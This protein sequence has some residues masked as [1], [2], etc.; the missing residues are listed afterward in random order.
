M[1]TPKRMYGCC[2][3]GSHFKITDLRKLDLNRMD[4]KLVQ[5][6]SPALC[7]YH[8]CRDCKRTC[9][10]CH[11]WVPQLQLRVH[12]LCA[13]CAVVKPPPKKRVRAC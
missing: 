6:L 2:V 11:A 12:G 7:E 13:T 5:R 9:E 8:L 4:P 10:Q 3:C 1:F